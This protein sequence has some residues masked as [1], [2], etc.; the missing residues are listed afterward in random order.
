MT[1]VLAVEKQNHS[2][3]NCSPEVAENKIARKL[4]RNS[5]RASAGCKA[6][7][8]PGITG[9]RRLSASACWAAVY[10]ESENQSAR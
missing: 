3:V 1:D 5:Q 6:I 2:G 9:F 4:K 8:G 10:T 7:F